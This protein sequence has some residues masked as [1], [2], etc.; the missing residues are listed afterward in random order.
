VILWGDIREFPLLA[1][2]QF[3]S[4]QRRSGV[5]EIQDFEEQ[6]AVYLRH[7]QIEAISLP[8]ADE[9]FGARLVAAGALTEKL[10]KDCL[11]RFSADPSGP[12]LFAL[13]LEA[14]RADRKTLVD[15]VD[16]HTADQVMQLM[17]WRTGAFRLVVPSE[18][19]RFAVVPS[20]DVENLLLEAY[21][22]VDEG[23]RPRREKI[24][25]EEELCL[26]CTL[27][28]SPLIKARFLKPDICLWRSMPA[29]LKDPEFAVVLKKKR[30]VEPED[31]G[32]DGDLPFL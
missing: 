4:A 29:V 10:V 16:R 26:S 5:L 32:E 13:L 20:L 11:L 1:V 7:G 23:E 8:E 2:L 12:P 22:R 30:A 17:Y 25:V 31:D 9:E 21:R 19:V 14:A 18:P 3:L 24:V 28:C 6:G 15:L 27:E